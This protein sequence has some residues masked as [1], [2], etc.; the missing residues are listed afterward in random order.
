MAELHAEGRKATEE[1]A[2]EIINRLEARNNYIP[3]SERTRR[4]Y[5]YVLLKEYRAYVKN[6]SGRGRQGFGT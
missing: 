2:A 6:K 5:G 3:S 4:E 1:A